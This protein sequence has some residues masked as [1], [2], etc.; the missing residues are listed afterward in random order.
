M[1]DNN[2]IEDLQ[3]K[4]DKLTADNEA[5]TKTVATQRELERE[6]RGKVNAYETRLQGLPDDF[7][8]K[9]YNKLMDSVKTDSLDVR[10]AEQEKRL[11][12]QHELKLKALNEQLESANGLVQKHVVDASLSKALLDAN[13]SP[14]YIEAV[15]ALHK[16]KVKLDGETVYL[17]DLPIQD[18]LKEW[19]N[20]DAGKHFVKADENNGGGVAN[21]K[22]GA[23]GAKTITREQYDA[24][25]AQYKEFFADGGK[26]IST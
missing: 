17:G 5:L 6:Q 13:I 24:N 7:D 3:A 20:S 8:V 25:P 11:T 18:G 4:I 1:T 21:I 10:L 23:G 16:D 14:S 12:A 15:K 9:A 19:A 26:I 22:N 2:Q